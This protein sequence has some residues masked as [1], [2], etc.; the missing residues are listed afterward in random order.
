MSSSVNQQIREA[1]F[2]LPD[3]RKL[4]WFDGPEQLTTTVLTAGEVQQFVTDLEAERDR[5]KAALERYAH[6]ENWHDCEVD[7]GVCVH[8]LAMEPGGYGPAQAA[9]KENDD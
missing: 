2:A 7:G 4:A 6:P 9:L 5:Y 3:G 8:F 1:I